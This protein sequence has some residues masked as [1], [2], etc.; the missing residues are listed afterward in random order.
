MRGDGAA[1][2]LDEAQPK[3]PLS[4]ASEMRRIIPLARCANF[5][6]LGGYSGLNGRKTR[7]GK[8]YRSMTPEYITPEDY[9]AVKDLGIRLVVDLRGPQFKTSGPLGEAPSRRV[10]P[11]R[12][13]L[14]IMT[15]AERQA[16]AHM[17]PEEALPIVLTHMGKTLARAASHIAAEPGPALVHCRLG[18]DRTGVFTAV[19]LRLLGVS[20]DDVIEDYLL[21]APFIEEAHRLLADSGE[22]IFGGGESRVAQEPPSRAAIEA[23]LNELEGHYGGAEAY[24]RLHGL[25]KRDVAKLIDGLLE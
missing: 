3:R 21:S 17:A 18:K 10:T 25:R 8:L 5:R 22:P 24:L 7:W 1:S 4:A 23:V 13:R 6:D 9:A 19:L 2:A 16:Y 12:K 15:D 20:E 11:G 14:F